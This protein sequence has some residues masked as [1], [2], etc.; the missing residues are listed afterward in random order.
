MVLKP[1]GGFIQTWL[2]HRDADWPTNDTAYTFGPFR[3]RG[4][5]WGVVKHADG[6]VDVSVSGPFNQTFNVSGIES[7][8]PSPGAEKP[9]KRVNLMLE[10]KE[11]VLRVRLNMVAVGTRTLATA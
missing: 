1:E 8:P 9:G 3:D 6:T 10:W 5:E 4:F 2:Q 7:I 11:G